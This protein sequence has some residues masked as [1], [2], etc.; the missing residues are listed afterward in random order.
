M[1]LYGKVGIS[2]VMYSVAI[3]RYLCAEV[4]FA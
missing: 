4:I 3:V 1:C 2:N